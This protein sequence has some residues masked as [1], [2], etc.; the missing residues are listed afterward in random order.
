MDALLIAT[1]FMGALTLVFLARK[2]WKFFHAPL[3]F[4]VYFSPTGGCTDVVVREIAAARHE[5]LVLAYGF[6]SRPISQALVDAK[7]R[8]VH[9]E[10]V[11][12]HSN[13]KDPH[14]DLPFLLE[15]KL[16]PLIDAHHAIAHNKVMLVDGKTLLTGSFNFTQ[17]A[18]SHNAENLLVIKGAPELAAAYR[19]DFAHHKAHARAAEVDAAA[20]AQAGGPHYHPA[21]GHD[22]NPADAIAPTTT[23][24][25]AE[26][27]A[28]LRKGSAPD[29]D[30]ESH[31]KAA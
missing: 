15:Q 16:A 29:E 4:E 11:L 2:V 6:T 14:S 26:L 22:E 13:E 7:F 20:H 30:R 10:V 17:A 12:D 31:K 24:A 21:K 8:G 19:H 18:E 3:H 25:A 1:G 23:L 5:V 27:F 28:R 9:V